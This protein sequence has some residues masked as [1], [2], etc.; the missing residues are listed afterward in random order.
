MS[1]EH[2]PEWVAAVEDGNRIADT[3]RPPS[4]P[5]PTAPRVR[6]GMWFAIRQLLASEH[7]LSAQ[8]LAGV[9]GIE[10]REASR[11]IMEFRRNNSGSMFEARW[12]GTGP[13]KHWFDSQRKADSFMAAD[14]CAEVIRKPRAIRVTVGRRV[15]DLPKHVAR[16]V[17]REILEALEC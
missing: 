17:A 7:G 3:M 2:T 11:A 4:T 13:C 1:Y 14:P 6:G 10:P 16:R 8:R 5:V 15:V 9:A 12:P